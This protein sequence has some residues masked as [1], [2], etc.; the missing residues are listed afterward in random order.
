MPLLALGG[1]GGGGGREG[2][3]PALP[4]PGCCSSVQQQRADMPPTT[5]RSPAR[6]AAQ[7]AAAA[8]RSAEGRSIQLPAAARSPCLPAAADLPGPVMRITGVMRGRERPAI[9]AQLRITEA[10]LY[11]E[12]GPGTGPLLFSFRTPWPLPAAAADPLRCRSAACEGSAAS[13]REPVQLRCRGSWSEGSGC[14]AERVRAR[15]ARWPG[16][17]RRP[18]G[19]ARPAA[20]AAVARVGGV[21][22]Q[23]VPTA[24]LSEFGRGSHA[25]GAGWGGST[26]HS[27][28]SG[29]CAAA[30]FFVKMPI[31]P[32]FSRAALRLRE[33]LP[34]GAA[35]CGLL[36][37][38]GSAARA[39]A[40][41]ARGTGA[42]P[43]GWR[44]SSQLPPPTASAGGV[45][46]GAFP[47]PVCVGRSNEKR[48]SAHRALPLVAFKG[49]LGDG[50]SGLGLSP[51]PTG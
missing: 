47:S 23:P 13:S 30:P 38:S 1:M 40:A 11:A 35:A 10:T 3:R 18:S 9:A 34:D 4:G 20:A 28:V 25:G 27:A 17:R 44:S 5:A 48:G 39:F 37:L 12:L 22:G 6:A 50:R 26:V 29:C 2:G 16:R 49:R 51:A 19:N 33:H 42:A 14:A 24:G 32:A 46:G 45:Q 15:P 43:T 36:L 8:G 31:F 21:P 7:R 41:A